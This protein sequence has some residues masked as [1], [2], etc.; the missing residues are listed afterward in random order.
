MLTRREHI[1]QII[2]D[3]AKANLMS[4]RELKGGHSAREY[5]A[6]K[7]A[8]LRVHEQ[9]PSLSSTQLGLVFGRHHTSILYAMGRLTKRRDR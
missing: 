8:I 9:Y 2:S 5:R 1:K 7:A 4:Y 3:T 6:R